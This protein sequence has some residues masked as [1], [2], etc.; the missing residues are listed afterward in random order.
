MTD[1]RQHCVW[2]RYVPGETVV[3]AYARYA[4]LGAGGC[5]MVIGLYVE[6]NRPTWILALPPLEDPPGPQAGLA[7]HHEARRLA[8]EEAAR[9]AEAVAD[10]QDRTDTTGYSERD[11]F[12]VIGRVDGASMAASAIRALIPA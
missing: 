8:L 7:A 5:A 2:H 10:G 11:C 6:R 3:D 9:A 12:L 1:A 4:L